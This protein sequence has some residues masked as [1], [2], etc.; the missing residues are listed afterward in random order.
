LKTV[1]ENRFEETVEKAQSDQ[2]KTFVGLL[3]TKKLTCL[4]GTM[5]TNEESTNGD[6]DVNLGKFFSSSKNKLLT[7]M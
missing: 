4:N 6:V 1:E 2:G 3:I 7:L 5:K